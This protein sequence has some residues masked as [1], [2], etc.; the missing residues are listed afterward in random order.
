MEYNIIILV[1][2]VIILIILN[3]KDKKIEN[4]KKNNHFKV[5]VTY[6]NPGT[7]YLDKC[8]DSIK[9]QKYKN[10]QLCLLN[11]ASTKEI[12]ELDL[13]SN[14]YCDKNNWI[15]YK[16]ENNKGP[17]YS[18]IKATELLNPKDEDI[19]VLIDGDDKLNNS[20]VLNILNNKYQ[21]DTLITFGNFV[22]VNNKGEKSS[23]R[24]KC[25]RVNLPELAVNR[26]FRN[27]PGER[28][29][30][31]HLKTYKYKLYRNL[32]LDDLK[33]NG[34]YIK[35]ATD[36]AL[37]YPLLE[38]A[39]KK[40]KCINE[41]LY[42]YTID[43]T[44]S[45]HNS[46]EKKRKQKE[47]LRYVQ[48][49]K[50]YDIFDFNKLNTEFFND[51]GLSNYERFNINLKNYQNKKKYAL[52]FTGGPTLNEFKKNDIPEEIYNNCYIIAVKNA[53]NYLDIINIK[54][55]FVVTNFF[56][57]ASRINLNLLDKH[58]TINIGLILENESDDPKFIELKNKINYLVKLI[59][60]TKKNLMELVI[61]DIKALEFENINNEIYTGWGHIMLE[62]AIPLCIFLKTKNIITIGW[63]NNSKNIKHWD[64]IENFD[65]IINGINL[66]SLDTIVNNFSPYLHNYLWKHYKIRI[67]KINKKS[68]MKLPLFK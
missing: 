27:L 67:Y 30:F 3:F 24:V 35:S 38:M 68:A 25:H 54:P 44:E 47:N 11:D 49:L 40:I 20:N 12:K 21:D 59:N 50:K 1:I 34:E 22:R 18:R 15:Y 45:F 6:Y 42:D 33:K 31:S 14:K 17:C 65:N 13:I 39:G 7:K 48:G 19:I 64:T 57:S 52:I 55:D 66:S 4:F 60:L 51:N 5:V 62:L 9:K 2:L 16:N 41:I 58:N 43:H 56:N 46:P 28:Y 8:L 29:P 32:N 37:M 61:K 26:K 36:A 63:D 23:K 10:F 53:I